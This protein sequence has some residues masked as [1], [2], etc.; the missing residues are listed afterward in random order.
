MEGLNR[1]GQ[2]DHVPDGRRVIKE[3]HQ[4][5]PIPSPIGT[6]R[7]IV[8]GPDLGESYCQMLCMP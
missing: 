7:W 4:S 6:D 5:R 8:C 3:D 1:I 2:I